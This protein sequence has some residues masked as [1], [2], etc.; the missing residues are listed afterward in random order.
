MTRPARPIT[1]PTHTCRSYLPTL[2]V[3]A[4]VRMLSSYATVLTILL[5]VYWRSGVVANVLVL[6]LILGGKKRSVRKRTCSPFKSSTSSLV[7]YHVS[8]SL[9]L[10]RALARDFVL[11][12][13]MLK[14]VC[15]KQ[16]CENAALSRQL[17]MSMKKRCVADF[18]VSHD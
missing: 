4:C 17:A 14:H 16:A 7:H 11:I 8:R 2:V 12:L 3:R 5:V 18:S 6:V 1:L 9:S 13:S 15:V 10:L